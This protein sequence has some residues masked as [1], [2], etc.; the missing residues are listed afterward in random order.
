MK[1]IVLCCDGT[2]NRADQESA[3]KPCPTN[4]IK[5]AYRLC[6]RADDIEQII[7]YDQGVGTGD[8]EDKLLGG[9]TGAGLEQNI[10]DAYIFLMANYESG[11]EIYIFGFSRGA[12]TARSISGMI[13]KCGIIRREFVEQY[14]AAETLYHD[15]NVKA[16]DPAGKQFRTDFSLDGAKDTPVQMIG[17]WDT[18]GALGIPLRGLRAHNR[19]EFQFLDTELNPAV[20]FAFH[21]LAIDEHRG[22]F[23]P[24]LWAT[25]DPGQ[26]VRQVWFPGVHSDVGGGYKE[27]DLSDITL[28]WMIQCATE[29]GLAFDKAVT[30]KHLLHPKADGT[31][32]E[33]MTLFYRVEGKHE[34]PIGALPT[35]SVHPSA[36]ERWDKVPGYRPNNLRDYFKRIG[37]PR[38]T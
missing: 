19:E 33:S 22:P 13:H 35:E 3:G 29:A 31:M 20:K 36:A 18:V 28:E 38:G 21:A 14:L 6:K 30:D 8:L 23:E 11:D 10:H 17:V 32:H 25:S 27:S 4:V 37:D 15:A 34:R 26:T 2:W 16:G 24:T 12:F 5:I 7:Y 1:R 9:A